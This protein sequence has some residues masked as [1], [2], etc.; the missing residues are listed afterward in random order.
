MKLEKIAVKIGY[1][2]K[3]EDI[4]SKFHVT[5][6]EQGGT[7]YGNLSAMSRISIQENLD[8]LTKEVDRSEWAMPGNLVNACYDP[9]R[10]D[11]TFPAAILQKP[12]YDLHQSSSANYGGIGAVI[13]HEISHA[14]DNNGAQFDEYGNM[15]NWWQDQD[16]TEFKKNGHKI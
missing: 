7:L 1:P 9:S 2:D 5:P 3:I 16:F 11:I 10:N 12:F 13:A 4:Y 15:N 6:A 8:K 14:F